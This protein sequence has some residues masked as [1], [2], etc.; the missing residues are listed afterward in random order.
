M[1]K[2]A[3]LVL[4]ALLAFSFTACGSQPDA[5][6]ADKTASAAAQQTITQNGSTANT[7]TAAHS[8]ASTASGSKSAAVNPNTKFT[9]KPAPKQQLNS[10]TNDIKN[11][12]SQIESTLNALD[13]APDVNTDNIQ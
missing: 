6:S 5:K 9:S 2:L 4:S 1:K 7:A 11:T 3:A 12:M 13:A 10:A 8:A